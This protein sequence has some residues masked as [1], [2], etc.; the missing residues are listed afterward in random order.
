MRWLESYEHLV[1]L[2]R[3][4][5]DTRLVCV[6]DRESDTM[7][8]FEQGQRSGWAVDVLVRARHDRVLPDKKAGKLWSRVMGSKVLGV[9]E[10]GYP[11]DAGARLA[12]C[13][14]SCVPS[15]WCCVRASPARTANPISRPSR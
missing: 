7:A 10:F 13:A 6:G 5:P 4:L 8:L 15:V 1:G 12:G 14:K 3:Q 11:A 2:S 9:V